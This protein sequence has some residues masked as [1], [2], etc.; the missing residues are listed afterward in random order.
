MAKTIWADDV[1][2]VAGSDPVIQFLADT[3]LL[4]TADKI[5]DDEIDRGAPTS[6]ADAIA[7]LDQLCA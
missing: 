5:L 2:V 1:D 7:L 4:T 3:G 6:A